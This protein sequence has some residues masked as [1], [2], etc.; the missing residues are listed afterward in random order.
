MSADQLPEGRTVTFELQ[1]RR[2]GKELCHCRGPEGMLH[3]PYWYGYWRERDGHG[4]IR[5]KSAYVGKPAKD[6][7]SPNGQTTS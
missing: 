2:C 7:G 4:G 3:G 6:G 1:Y 5:V